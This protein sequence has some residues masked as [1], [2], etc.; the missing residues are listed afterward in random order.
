MLFRQLYDTE[1]STYTYLLADEETREAVIIDSVRD[2]VERD[3]QLVK[4]LHLKLLYSLD[5]HIHADHVTGSGVLRNRLGCKTVTSKHGGAACSN[6]HIDDGDVIRFGKHAIEVRAT[7]GHTDGC[8]TY[9]MAHEKMAFTGDALLIRGTGRTDFQQ[10]SPQKLFASIKDKIFSLS[11]DTVLY[12]GHD[13]K[14]RMSTTVGEERAFNPRVNDNVTEAQF[15]EIMNN[16]KLARPKKIDEAVPANL[17]CGLLPNEETVSGEAKPE[18]S[19]APIVRTPTGIPEVTAQ[20]VAE[21]GSEARLVDVREVHE[22]SAELG[23]VAHTELVPLDTVGA[24]AHNWNRE[25]PIVVI[26]RSGGR[27]GR[28]AQL[29]ESM[30]FKRIASMAGG[31]LAWNQAALPVNRSVAA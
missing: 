13:Y 16:L 28:A 8:L 1:T 22:Y 27:S 26:C 3:V 10:G 18:R 21:H 31:M 29:L 19:W 7:P 11:D 4:E 17:H 5:T 14:G 9:V 6:V 20:W 23:H 24:V 12:P 25:E 2:Q 30:G 15:V